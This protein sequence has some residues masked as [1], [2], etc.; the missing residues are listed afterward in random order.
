MYTFE[1]GGM[2]RNNCNSSVCVVKFAVNILARNFRHY[3]P[4]S[5][6]STPDDTSKARVVHV[7]LVGMSCAHRG[8]PE[9]VTKTSASRFRSFSAES[10]LSDA[11]RDRSIRTINNFV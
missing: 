3:F 9:R 5:F 7:L 11:S 2:F 10:R 8:S 1:A 6:S 4:L